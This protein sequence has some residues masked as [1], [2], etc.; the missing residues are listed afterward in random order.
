MSSDNDVDQALRHDYALID[1]GITDM[2]CY[3]RVGKRGFPDQVFTSIDWNLNAAAQFTIYLNHHLH[4]L[5]PQRLLVD[6][7]P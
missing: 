7:G 1:P 3:F 5:G 4:N 2:L 6:V